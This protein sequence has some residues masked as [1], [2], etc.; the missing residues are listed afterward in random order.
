MPYL[1][2]RQQAIDEINSTL[3]KG[4]CLVCHIL[5]T[6]NNFILDRGK[7]TTTVLSKYP[8]TWGQTM[9]LLNEHKTAVAELTKEE[10]EELTEK[11]RVFAIRIERD[12]K[13]LRCYISSLGAAENLPN[14][15]PHIHFNIIPV[16]NSGDKPSEIYTWEKGVYAGSEDE[17][18]ELLKKLG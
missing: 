10:W 2:P 16:Y 3:E 6:E 11:S 7:Y 1:I 12:L 13:P 14:T 4:D 5:E 15:C 8:R 9:I 17:W 18:K